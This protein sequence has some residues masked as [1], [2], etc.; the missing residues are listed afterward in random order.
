MVGFAPAA[1][2]V[3]PVSLEPLAGTSYSVSAAEDFQLKAL[4]TNA[5]VSGGPEVLKFRVVDA[6]AKLLVNQLDG[7]DQTGYDQNG[8]DAVN[9]T[10]N[11]GDVKAGALDADDKDVVVATAL[12]GGNE[13]TAAEF[14]L[15]PAADATFSVT[16]QAWMDFD[17]DGAED[18]FLG[19]NFFAVQR[20][21]PR[22]D[23]GRGIVLLGGGDGSFAAASGEE[24]GVRVHGEQRGAALAA[25]NA[26][27]RVDLLVTQNGART[28]LF[29]NRNGRPGLRVRLNA[30]PKNPT[31]VG[32]VARLVF[33][34][35]KGPARQ[36]AAGSGYWSQDSATLVMATPERP[37]E[38][39]VRWPD[40]TEQTEAVAA[41]ANEISIERRPVGR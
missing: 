3:D 25:F 21:T 26:D 5:A 14:I 38:V 10:A 35:R 28:R 40:G 20:E 15:V 39:Q 13:G 22:C 29:E 4:F 37:T 30:G 41:G 16:V 12:T 31:G 18:V 27:G 6:D 32:A 17:G 24:S 23:G 11:A 1:N 19:Q 2:A 9:V 33:D 34:G 8:N 7:V 36:V